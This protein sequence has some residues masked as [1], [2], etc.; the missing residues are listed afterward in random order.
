MTLD[1]LIAARLLKARP[2]LVWRAL[3]T[4]ELLSRFWG[5]HHATVPDS[6]TVDLRVGGGFALDT[7]GPHGGRRLRFT[8][9][10]IDEPRRLAFSEPATGIVTHID[11]V[12]QGDRTFLTVHQR[13]VPPE[14]T[15]EDARRGLAGILD[16]LDGLVAGLSPH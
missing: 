9:L 16:R 7:A 4:P 3:T 6:V 14:L 11:L 1:H 10:E 15:G 8:Y 13:R 12:P 5:G 2:D